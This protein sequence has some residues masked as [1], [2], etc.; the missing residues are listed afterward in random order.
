VILLHEQDI[1]DIPATP[2]L[3][4]LED[5]SA[6]DFSKAYKGDHVV[7]FSAGAGV[8]GGEERTNKVDYEGALK[9]FGTIGRPL[10]PRLILILVSALDIRDPE[11]ISVHYVSINFIVSS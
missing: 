4:S 3:L 8:G 11:R 7:Y 1:R 2:L 9:G 6:A 5:A 10:E